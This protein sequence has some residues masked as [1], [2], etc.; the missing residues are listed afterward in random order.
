M[1]A[2]FETLVQIAADE[3]D[4]EVSSL[5]IRDEAHLVLRATFGLKAEAVGA[6]RMHIDEG[7]TGAAYKAQEP[8]PVSEAAAHPLY[9]YFPESG[10]EQFRSFLGIP[11]PEGLGVLVFQT[12]ECRDFSM[13]ELR[14]AVEWARRIGHEWLGAYKSQAITEV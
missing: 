5:Y 14:A 4:M 3:M 6:V 13:S 1:D 11:L 2:D 10:E 7:L 12:R 9:R 8:L